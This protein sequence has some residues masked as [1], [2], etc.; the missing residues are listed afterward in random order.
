MSI[1]DNG[2]TAVA[3]AIVAVAL[4]FA[5]TAQTVSLQCVPQRAPYLSPTALAASGDGKTL[6]IACATANCIVCLDTASRVVLGSI[7][8]PEPPSGLVLSA[9]ER[10][11]FVTCAA[12]ES[13]V[14]VIDLGQAFAS[15]ASPGRCNAST[16]QRSNAPTP[17]PAAAALTSRIVARITT[18]HTA[19]A[20]TLS[21]DGKMLYVCN[22]FNDCIGVIDLAAGK[23]VGRIPV[24]REPVAAALT[25]DGK[26]LLVANHLHNE[27]ANAAYV[28]AVVSAIDLAQGK[29][30][31]EFLLPDGSGALKDIR[32]S[33]DGKYAAVT[34]ILAQYRP[35][36]GNLRSLWMNA[37]A[38][39][40]IDLGRMEVLA[41]T[42]LDDRGRGAANP[43]GMAWSADGS[44][45]L[46]AHAGTHELSL[47]DFAALLKKLLQLPAPFDSL[48][49]RGSAYAE[50]Q[51]MGYSVPFFAGSR[52][53]VKLPAGDLGPRAV[54][55]AGHTAY[56]ANYFSDTLSVI[57]LSNTNSKPESIP[58]HKSEIRNPKS[59]INEVRKGEFFFHDASICYQ[60]WQSCASCHPGGARADGLNWD[61]LNDGVG[62]PKNTKSLL[63]AFQTPPAMWLGVRETAETAVRAG[64]KH[65]LFTQQPEEVGAAIDAYLK[66]LR[67]VPS[68]H[69]VRGKLSAA[70]RRGE[71]VFSR[72]GCAECHPPPL[73]TDLHQY[74][75]GTRRA[76]D[77]PTVKFDTPA[78]VELWRT[79][80]YLH[81]G[82]AAT[83][84]EVL[85]SR[86]PHDRHGKTSNLTSQEITNLCAYLLS[87]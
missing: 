32:I 47:I 33:P 14:C 7:P 27:A 36:A 67:P 86:N 1:N 70:A 24:R 43:W 75:V 82:S 9:E 2:S 39:T 60:G 49:A 45:L 83:V 38:L 42:L 41:T 51:P 23:E 40:V 65:I 10:R 61:L 66:S 46:V 69:L 31:A 84:R 85:T 12:P 54:T 21:L 77:G 63:F 55:I 64:I 44:T 17:P 50:S 13:A 11:L 79:A 57:D 76:F 15:A 22:R 3:S 74:D 26:H 34:H 62:N 71:K 37:N 81:D 73:F 56:V 35:A 30:T 5:A 48:K 87:L 29:V 80:P 19:M 25:R 4:Q 8:V 53:R 72:A 58:L 6:Y 59:E 52:R 28:A 68:P 20:P 78:L 18:G 16:L